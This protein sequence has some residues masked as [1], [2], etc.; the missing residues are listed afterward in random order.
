[1]WNKIFASM[2]GTAASLGFLA[3]ELAGIISGGQVW[4]ELPAVEIEAVPETAVKEKHSGREAVK[5][6]PGETEPL[7]G[8]ME[9]YPPF[10][11]AREWSGYEEYLLTKIAMAEAG[12]ESVQ[13]KA[14]VI[15][16]VLNR[17][18]SDKFPDSIEAVIYQEDQFSPVQDGA[19]DRMEPDA[20]CWT[21][22]NV[23]KESQYDFSGGALYF[24]NCKES[25]NWHSKNLN[26]LYQC[27]RHKFYQ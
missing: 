2:L 26:F 19:F 13:G 4:T 22:L 9:M 5:A 24:E 10:T 6:E 12:G 16:V 1:M 8:K 21:A 20:D 15:M 17:V 23:I 14:L 27:G 25:D 18:Q 11:Y 3:V 7:T